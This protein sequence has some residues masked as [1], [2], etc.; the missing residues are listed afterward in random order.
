MSLTWRVIL[1]ITVCLFLSPLWAGLLMLL[2]PA[3]AVNVITRGEESE[4]IP[5]FYVRYAGVVQILIDVA[6]LLQ[7]GT[8]FQVHLTRNQKGK[9]TLVKSTYLVFFP[10]CT[11]KYT[12]RKGLTLE[13]AHKVSSKL[14]PLNL[15][16]SLIL[17]G[18]CGCFGIVYF[19]T[20]LST[21]TKFRIGLRSPGHQFDDAVII[22]ESTDESEFAEVVEIFK[23]VSNIEIR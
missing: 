14:T 11:Q 9:V 8:F 10:R 3:T 19:L 23:S 16:V 4:K 17:L 13:T 1:S 6:V 5:E 2:A 21:E 7:C 22:F 20:C 18:A 12:L 15:W